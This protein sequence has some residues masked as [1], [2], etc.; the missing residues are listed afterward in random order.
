MICGI[1]KERDVTIEHVR[2]HNHYPP[3]NG[4]GFADQPV[5]VLQEARDLR[6]RATEE[7]VYLSDGG[8][9]YA[10]VRS[11]EGRLY[12]KVWNGEHF[13]YAKGAIMRLYADQRITAEQAKA[14]GDLYNRCVFCARLLTN[15]DPGCSVDR[16]YG[17]VCAEREGLPWGPETDLRA[18]YGMRADGEPVDA[19]PRHEPIEH[20]QAGF[21]TQSRFD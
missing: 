16:G 13:R 9:Y 1:C 4:S 2:G 19:P 12:A 11:E 8:G 20:Y 6:E 3:L 18:Q 5:L 17:P 14:F 21:T 10:V 7:G 15:T